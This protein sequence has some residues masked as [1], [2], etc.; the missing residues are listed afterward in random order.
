MK[1]DEIRIL[2]ADADQPERDALCRA[3]ADSGFLVT[4]VASTTEGLRSV[5]RLGLPHLMIVAPHINGTDD[6]MNLC[7]EIHLSA[8]VP[9]IA[10]AHEPLHDQAAYLIE[11]CADDVVLLPASPE[12]IVSRVRR[13]LRRLSDF[14]YRNAAASQQIAP[15]VRL[16]RLEQSLDVDG[17]AVTLTDREAALLDLLMRHEKR[18]LSGDFL[19]GQ[20]WPGG[21]VGRGTLRVTIH[22]LR[23]KIEPLP[24]EPRHI[25]SVRGHGYTFCSDG[26]LSPS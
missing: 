26:V 10:I 20:V 21:R 16:N 15:G 9:V 13:L 5:E 19:M 8:D 3:L 18:I 12:E 24:D 11:E 6:G 23:Q 17:R 25:L 14:S 2:I 1:G 7:R 4:C 22:R